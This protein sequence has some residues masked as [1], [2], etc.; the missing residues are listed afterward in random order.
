MR[1]ADARNP[2]VSM[3]YPRRDSRDRDC[4]EYHLR[5]LVKCL[6]LYIG[7]THNTDFGIFTAKAFSEGDIIMAD[8][9]GDYFD[10]VLSYDELQ[11]LGYPIAFTLQVGIDAFKLPTGSIEDFTNHSCDPNTGIRLTEKGTGHP[12]AA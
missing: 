7:N 12:G 9:D 3:F 4:F 10:R 5:K 8:E 6:Y 1:I 11:E 2:H